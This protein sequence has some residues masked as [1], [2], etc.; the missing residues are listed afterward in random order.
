MENVDFYTIDCLARKMCHSNQPDYNQ[1]CSLLED[2]YYA[3]T[4]G[5][6]HIIIDEGQD[7]G[8]NNI[9]ELLE[10][11]V[12]ENEVFP[13]TFYIFYDKLQL[14][15]GKELSKYIL[16][17]DCK[18]TLYKNCRNTLNI[19]KTSLRPLRETNRKAALNSIYIEF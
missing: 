18:L 9:I 17:S 12:L 3:E 11:N 5:Y 7:F 13:G 4:F 6:R 2:C 15:Q 16:E 14:V 1:F 8:Q 19:A 10:M